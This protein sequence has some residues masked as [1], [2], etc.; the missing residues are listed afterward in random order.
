MDGAGVV[1]DVGV[2]VKERLV[3]A[4]NGVWGDWWCTR[5]RPQAGVALDSPAPDARLPRGPRAA[6]SDR[7]FRGASLSLVSSTSRALRNAGHA[8]PARR[9]SV[10]LLPPRLASLPPR[11]RCAVVRLH[12]SGGVVASMGWFDRSSSFLRGDQG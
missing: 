11:P 10:R 1:M 12:A 4:N 6:A 3:A 7:R 5:Y 8:A 9:G 2:C